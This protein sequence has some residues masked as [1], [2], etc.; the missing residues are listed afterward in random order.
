MEMRRNTVSD[1][2]DTTDPLALEQQVCFALSIA[3]RRP[4]A[5]TSP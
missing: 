4:V 3:A 2:V 5:T 1:S